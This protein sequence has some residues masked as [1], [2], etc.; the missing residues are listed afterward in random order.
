VLREIT[1]V[2]QDAPGL[3]RRWFQDDYFDLFLWLEPDG[4]LTAFQLGYDRSRD[5]YLLAW[6]RDHGYRHCRVDSGEDVPFTNMTP[7]LTRAG[8]FP[9][10]RVVSEFDARSAR[11]DAPTRRGVR[12]KLVR[13]LPAARRPRWARAWPR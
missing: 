1:T 13:Y 3:R 11:L 5:E 6:H 10:S 4:E 2:R 9:K 7:L 12:E 8:R